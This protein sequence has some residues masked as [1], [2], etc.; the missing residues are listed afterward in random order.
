MSSGEGDV[1][2]VPPRPCPSWN[3]LQPTT[4]TLPNRICS[5]SFWPCHLTRRKRKYPNLKCTLL[6]TLV[7]M[8]ACH[9]EQCP[10]VNSKLNSRGIRSTVNGLQVNRSILDLEHYIVESWPGALLCRIMAC[11]TIHSISNSLKI[12]Y[13]KFL[14]GNISLDQSAVWPKLS[15]GKLTPKLV[16]YMQKN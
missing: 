11:S 9:I 5:W 10:Y 7:I 12:G 13:K 1:L 3:M 14:V 16:Y 15:A 8:M 6:Q 4:P 2:Y